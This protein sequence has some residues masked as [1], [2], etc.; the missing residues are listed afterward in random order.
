MIQPGP[1]KLTPTALI[2]SVSSIVPFDT[3]LSSLPDVSKVTRPTAELMN[4]AD[5]RYPEFHRNFVSTRRACD[6]CLCFRTVSRESSMVNLF[7]LRSSGEKVQIAEHQPSCRFHNQMRTLKRSQTVEFRGNWIPLR[8]AVYLTT[9]LYNINPSINCVKVLGKDAPALRL[10]NI[11]SQTLC[12]AGWDAQ[13]GPK[14]ATNFARHILR[15]HREGRASISDVCLNG[16]TSLDMIMNIFFVGIILILFSC[17][18][19][20]TNLAV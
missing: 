3:E 13:Y 14:F 5:V 4:V 6:G 20:L 16:L 1:S 11:S 15:L 19:D 2:T 8:I 12:W 10:Y 17:I 7:F 18:Y 9:T